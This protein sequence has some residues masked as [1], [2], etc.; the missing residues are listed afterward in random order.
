MSPPGDIR[1][2]DVLTGKLVWTFHT[3]PRPGEFGYDTWPKD[4]WKY[5]GGANT[6]GELTVDTE[7]GIAYF[8][9]GSPTYDY[10]GADRIGANLFG[11]S[12]RGARCAH[13]QAPVALPDG[14]PR[15]LGLRQQRGAA[16]DDHPP[17]RAQQRRRRPGGQDRLALRVRSRDGRADLADRRAAGADSPTCRVKRPGRHSRFRPI[18]RP[19]R[20]SSSTS[21][22][23]IRICRPAEYERLKQRVLEANNKGLFTPINHHRDGSHSRQQW[24]RAVR[25]HRRRTA[26]GRRLRDHAGQ[27]GPPPP[28]PAGRKRAR[29]RPTADA[30]QPST[31]STARSCH[32]ADR[33][34]TDEGVPLVHAA[35][36]PAN[37]IAAG[38]AALRLR[39]RSR[40]VLQTGKNR[41]P[42]FPHLID[43]RCRSPRAVSDGAAGRP[44]TRSRCRRPRRRAGA[45]G[46]ATGAHRRIG[47]R[48]GRGRRHRAR[49]TRRASA[50][51]RRRA[52]NRAA[53]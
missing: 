27:P 50:V 23:S 29:R 19:S 26:H 32:G 22:T 39:P 8:P 2:Y 46:R 13:G 51:S 47:I 28:A 3:V 7:R 30:R 36:D 18:R 6:W 14:A 31:S 37:N 53:T 48:R 34:G 40:A 49:R 44:R 43:D 11:S 41:M 4:A 9:T 24:R 38:A 17:Q 33:L 21:K 15:S 12:L 45:I 10:Y 25:R 1:A 20:S 5:V 52:T 35:A 42:A 16:A